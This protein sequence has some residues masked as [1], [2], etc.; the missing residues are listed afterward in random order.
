MWTSAVGGINS[1]LINY[2]AGR[3]HASLDLARDSRRLVRCP[4]ATRRFADIKKYFRL[5]KKRKE[6]KKT[7]AV[8]D[9]IDTFQMP[10]HCC[11]GSATK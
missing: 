11:K 2:V 4:D 5:K 9:A 6:E 1:F 8:A 10:W 3:L 7:I